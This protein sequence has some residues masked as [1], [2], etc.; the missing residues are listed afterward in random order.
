MCLSDEL[1]SFE[2]EREPQ[3]VDTPLPVHDPAEGEYRVATGHQ[4]TLKAMM[5]LIFVV[6]LS[7]GMIRWADFAM[8]TYKFSVAMT[9]TIIL[10]VAMGASV[11]YVVGIWIASL[12]R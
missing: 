6:A 9:G 10:A 5:F 12:R 1:D 7:L 8:S 11:G 4:F 3:Q 2:W